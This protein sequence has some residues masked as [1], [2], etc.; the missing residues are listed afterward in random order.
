MIL[1]LNHT[2]KNIYQLSF[3]PSLFWTKKKQKKPKHLAYS[4]PHPVLNKLS[5]ESPQVCSHMLGTSHTT[6]A[7]IFP[8]LNRIGR[9][10]CSSNY[11]GLFIYHLL[12][13]MLSFPCRRVKLFACSRYSLEVF[14]SKVHCV[15]VMLLGNSVRVSGPKSSQ[16]FLC[17]RARVLLQGQP[18]LLS[19]HIIHLEYKCKWQY[20]VIN[21]A[22]NCSF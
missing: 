14:W 19:D 22:Y 2:A 20:D 3:Q 16:S 21:L 7:K 6:P 10:D 17:T 1:Y 5:Q 11:V 18:L 15:G 8:V 12:S 13:P 9:L 4:I